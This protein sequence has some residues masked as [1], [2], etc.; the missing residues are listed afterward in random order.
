MLMV[1]GLEWKLPVML[2]TGTRQVSRDRL[3]KLVRSTENGT[4]EF[5]T[6]ELENG[7]T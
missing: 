1:N 4:F 3:G 5:G 6:H 2:T 7:I